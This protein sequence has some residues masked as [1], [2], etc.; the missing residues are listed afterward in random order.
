MQAQQFEIYKQALPYYEKAYE[1][2][3]SNIGVI[4]TLLGLYYNLEI[5]EKLKDLKAV[6]EGL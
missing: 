4:Q 1:I 5:T 6:Y 3:P 2:N